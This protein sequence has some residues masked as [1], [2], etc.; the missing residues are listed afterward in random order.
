ML[1]YKDDEDRSYGAT[2]MAIG[3]VVY[4]GA[5]M[6]GTISLDREPS[7]LLALSDEF[8]Y[9][10]SSEVS[11]KSSWTGLLRKY[12]LSVVM[13]ISNL[14][15]RT[16]TA[17][18]AEPDPKSRAMLHDA[19]IQEG[20]DECQLENDELEPMFTSYYDNL[21][22]VFSHYA[23]NNIARNMASTLLSHRN[24]SRLEIMELLDDL[25]AY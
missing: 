24:L 9:G 18:S 20:K 4:H 5:E 2:G 16:L 13:L 1:S 21:H 19:V 23:V 17:H 12:N 3:L 6:I 14:L 25:N 8:Y 11:A 10:N 7:Q 15:C 22:Q